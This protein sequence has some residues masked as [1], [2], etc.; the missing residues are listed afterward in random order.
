[1]HKNTASVKFILDFKS[2]STHEKSLIGHFQSYN[3]IW[4]S[5]NSKA[6]LRSSGRSTPTRPTID[7]TPASSIGS[8]HNFHMGGSTSS[9]GDSTIYNNDSLNT[10]QTSTKKV[11]VQAAFIV[12]DDSTEDTNIVKE[13]TKPKKKQPKVTVTSACSEH[14]ET[15]KQIEELS[16]FRTFLLLKRPNQNKC[17]LFAIGKEYGDAWLHSHGATKVQSVMGIQ[18]SVP[19]SG[20]F[21]GMKS[22]TQTTEQLIDNLFRDEDGDSSKAHID[23]EQQ[24]TSTPMNKN[25]KIATET[26]V[27]SPINVRKSDQ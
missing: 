19:K 22:P 7:N 25:R 24:R 12:D 23:T 15:K 11:R 5:R 10:S 17:T 2:L 8:M 21:F 20:G 3:T 18:S 16:M 4:A 14:L 1:M 27:R 13:E 6:P 9:I 26:E